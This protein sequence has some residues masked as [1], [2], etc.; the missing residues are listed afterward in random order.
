MLVKNKICWLDLSKLIRLN[1]SIKP[2]HK[3]VLIQYYETV[4]YIYEEM[5]QNIIL[6]DNIT[7]FGDYEP[8]D[9]TKLAASDFRLVYAYIGEKQNKNV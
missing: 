7:K 9:I 1:E 6:V 3:E 2:R 4:E 8:R 5:I